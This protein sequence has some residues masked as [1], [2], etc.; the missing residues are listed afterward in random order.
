MAR[1]APG[2]TQRGLEH[3]GFSRAKMV[4]QGAKPNSLSD[5]ARI[6]KKSVKWQLRETSRFF[7]HFSSYVSNFD[8][9]FIERFDNNLPKI[10][11]N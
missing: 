6:W 10:L 9:I 1:Y 5:A 2:Q 3:V 7:F 11:E 4:G 8:F